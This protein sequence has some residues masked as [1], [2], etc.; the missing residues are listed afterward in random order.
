MKAAY[1]YLGQTGALAS[2]SVVNGAVGL[3]DPS[4]GFATIG[5]LILIGMYAAPVRDW[6]SNVVGSLIGW[7]SSTFGGEVG[8][9]KL[10]PEPDKSWD[11]SSYPPPKRPS[12]LPPQLP[13]KR[14]P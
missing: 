2:R 1:G 13:C 5:A 11:W 14:T 12:S 4:E 10:Q 9:K 7:P 6:A 8:M 3:V